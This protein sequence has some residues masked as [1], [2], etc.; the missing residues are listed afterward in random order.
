MWLINTEASNLRPKELD[1]L[2]QRSLHFIHVKLALLQNLNLIIYFGQ[3]TLLLTYFQVSFVFSWI[4]DYKTRETLK[5]FPFR[6]QLYLS[7]IL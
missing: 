6:I 1:S 5:I 2:T 3:F 7:K 4:A